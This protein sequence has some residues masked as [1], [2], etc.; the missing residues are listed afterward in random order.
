MIPV[1]PDFLYGPNDD[2]IAPA[3]VRENEFGGSHVPDAC[4]KILADAKCAATLNMGSSGARL[5]HNFQI[6]AQE[7][8]LRM[9]KHYKGLAAKVLQKTSPAE[10]GWDEEIAGAPLAKRKL[11]AAETKY[12][13]DT[14]AWLARQVARLGK[15]ASEVVDH[16]CAENPHRNPEVEREIRAIAATL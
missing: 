5:V 3:S 15:N 10:S 1:I 13:Q 2:P 11:N 12:F 14:R 6:A 7:L 16:W 9:S 8:D 4:D